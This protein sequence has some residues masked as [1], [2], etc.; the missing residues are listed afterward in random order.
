MPRTLEPLGSDDSR[1]MPHI[2][3]NGLISCVKY[4]D[5]RSD[6]LNIHR[7]DSAWRRS[8]RTSARLGMARI[9]DA[10]KPARSMPVAAFSAV[11]SDHA[12]NENQRESA[13][14]AKRNRSILDA[15]WEAL[16]RPL[17]AY[18]GMIAYALSDSGDF[19]RSEVPYMSGVFSPSADLSFEVSSMIEDMAS[20]YGRLG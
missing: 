2:V 5:I 7:G 19:I 3:S 8:S 6:V 4:R 11:P 17:K 9:D 1:I 20:E 18:P 13:C 10:A 14:T 15:H 16:R 12:Q